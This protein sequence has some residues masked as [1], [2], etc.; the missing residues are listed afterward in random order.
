[1]ANVLIASLGESPVV[2]TA[3]YDLL[4]TEEKQLEL[5][6]IDQVV[7]LHP[8]KGSIPLGYTLI[9]DALAGRCDVQPCGLAFD[10]PNNIDESITFLRTLVQLVFSHQ[11]AGDTVYLSLAGGRKN[12]SALMALIVPLFSC[13]KKLYHVLDTNEKKRIHNF[14]S[15][16]DIIEFSENVRQIAMHPNLM[17]L[18]LID[19]PME[20]DK[21]VSDEFLYIM[22]DLTLDK[23]DALWNNDSIGADALEFY[24]V[25]SNTNLAGKL[26]QVFVTE[27]IRDDYLRMEKSDAFR[28]RR[29]REC[30]LQMRYADRLADES[31]RHGIIKGHS[32]IFHY[33]KRSDTAERPFYHTEPE[34]IHRYPHADV[35]KVII[36]G[37][38]RERDGSKYEPS[39]HQLLSLP[40]K[41]IYPA[42]SLFP[43]ESILVV[44]LGEKPM[45]ATQLYRLL[46][47]E[48]R[49]IHE[50]ILIY[51]ELSRVVATGVNL[52][53]EAFASERILC[54]DVPLIDVED[55]DS[56][57]TCTRYQ[58]LLE[59]TITKTRKQYPHC[60][61]D[62]SLSGGRKG[63]AALAVFAA[64]RQGIH[65]LYHT[66]I[67]N[68]LLRDEIEEQT[69]I[70]A[71]NEINRNLRY[72]RLFLRAYA[73]ND[74]EF[75]R[76]FTL[77]KI[78]VFL[79]PTEAKH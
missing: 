63:M 25:I 4:T 72:D 10:D 59:K 40:L 28:A 15:I 47:R 35:R 73:K 69:T 31:F 3:M 51:P 9:E 77:F 13:V 68:D 2:V 27:H 26:L 70:E 44:P 19:I 67:T 42:E 55:I 78:P 14:K 22:L 43:Q 56:P 53:K 61:I 74:E 1:M 71:L 6:H 57:D 65:Y 30:F 17:Q 54:Q 32:R 18:K 64:M 11:K 66:L 58:E 7:V 39:E 45:V 50:V 46:S 8:Q 79:P 75:A 16:N 36:S 37:L 21:H 12:M 41:P 76:N 24:H 20:E 33:Y 62:L 38:A 60:Q 49:T 52:V 23:I 34:G 48:N 5:G 29:F